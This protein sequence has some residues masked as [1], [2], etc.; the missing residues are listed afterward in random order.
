MTVRPEGKAITEV[1]LLRIKVVHLQIQVEQAQ[2]HIRLLTLQRQQEELIRH[3]F[4]AYLP[5]EDT[6]AY[7][8]DLDE[9]IIKLR[10]GGQQ[11]A[12]GAQE[13]VTGNV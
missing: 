9:G 12:H 5:G 6:A 1:E 13:Y 4:T 11:P 8:L 10:Q 7:V 3:T 2:A